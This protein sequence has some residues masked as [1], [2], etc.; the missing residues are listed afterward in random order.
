MQSDPVAE[1]ATPV[2]ARPVGTGLNRNMIGGLHV[3]QI[4]LDEV[5]TNNIPLTQPTHVP[6]PTRQNPT[7][8]IRRFE[9][10]TNQILLRK[11]PSLQRQDRLGQAS[12]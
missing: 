12:I 6:C 3:S 5:A 9:E 7:P 2:K 8:H 4:I 10:R 11:L 1:A